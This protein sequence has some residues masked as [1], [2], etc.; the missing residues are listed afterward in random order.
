MS[1]A[2]PFDPQD[3]Y[4]NMRKAQL[5]VTN[6]I[7][8]CEIASA[9][10]EDSLNKAGKQFETFCTRMKQH[11]ITQMMLE[12]PELRMTSERQPSVMFKNVFHTVE[13]VVFKDV[14]DFYEQNVSDFCQLCRK[15]P[16]NDDVVIDVMTFSFIPSYFRFFLTEQSL[17]YYEQF[18][19]DLIK[20]E[21]K[22]LYLRFARAAFV[23]P[24]F[25][26]FVAET[27]REVLAPVLRSQGTRGTDMD[28][29][30]EEIARRMGQEQNKRMIPACAKI[31]ISKAPEDW[32]KQVLVQCFLEPFAKDPKQFMVCNYFDRVFSGFL[33]EFVEHFKATDAFTQFQGLF[34][35]DAKHLLDQVIEDSFGMI[36]SKCE[37]INESE[38]DRTVYGTV[39]YQ[40]FKAFQAKK[41]KFACKKEEM[42]MFRV[43]G[44]TAP[45]GQE[46]YQRTMAPGQQQQE[47]AYNLRE[48]MKKAP[49]LP[50]NECL[51]RFENPMDIVKEY[52]VEH[53]P[54]EIMAQQY[55]FFNEAVYCIG[56]IGNTDFMDK[57]FFDAFQIEHD[58]KKD[59]EAFNFHTEIKSIYQR[60]EVAVTHSMQYLQ[61]TIIKSLA[62][63]E[64]CNIDDNVQRDPY[65]FRNTVLDLIAR[66][67]NFVRQNFH[68]VMNRSIYY[69]IVAEKLDYEKF[70]VAHMDLAALDSAFA[71]HLKKCDPAQATTG[72]V[73]QLLA[74]EN[75]HELDPWAKKLV[76]WTLENDNPLSKL[77]TFYDIFNGL[78]TVLVHAKDSSDAEPAGADDWTPMLIGTIRYAAP[79]KLMSC[80]A[81]MMDFLI[82]ENQDLPCLEKCGVIPAT[83]AQCSTTLRAI[84]LGDFPDFR[85][86]PSTFVASSKVSR[87]LCV[88]GQGDRAITTL[89]ALTGINTPSS[90]ENCQSLLVHRRPVHMRDTNFVYHTTFSRTKI[91]NDNW[92]AIVYCYE[93]TEKKNIGSIIKQFD[94]Y[95]DNA[96]MFSIILCTTEEKPAIESAIAKTFKNQEQPN[97]LDSM[98]AASLLQ[99]NQAS[100]KAPIVPL[101]VDNIEQKAKI[102]EKLWKR[103]DQ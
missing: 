88:V 99:L 93:P 26:L 39:D 13:K 52:L 16:K 91:P 6:E 15:L 10:R 12:N 4:E 89:M 100:K 77:F 103:F 5:F 78:S 80:L 18:L 79:P 101:A 24:Y 17:K 57:R 38:F 76:D 40:L 68:G 66:F 45:M 73:A 98:T 36:H 62:A 20:T 48:M 102:A 72:C 90:F 33:G 69:N 84:V 50:A 23:H 96:D 70:L 46:A 31:V 32:R 44:S 92:Y 30:T 71:M 25:L 65:L 61:M 97:L 56:L 43:F 60:S 1:A 49:L 53:V 7:A 86:P 8:F 9:V 83:H 41:G 59:V 74:R 42:I 28:E 37:A 47:V 3:F 64:G 2:G 29:L 14:G 19:E 58:M 85:F 21:D 55:H 87:K 94:R 67:S 35:H 81:Y 27:F 63:K 34:V 54:L 75:L 11:Y 95:R 51:E 22:D 82:A